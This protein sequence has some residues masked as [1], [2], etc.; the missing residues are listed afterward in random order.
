MA[1]SNKTDI[2]KFFNDDETV[3][4]SYSTKKSYYCRY[5]IYTDVELKNDIEFSTRAIPSE[6]TYKFMVVN[7]SLRNVYFINEDY[8]IMYSI[9]HEGS[10]NKPILTTPITTIPGLKY[11]VVDKLIEQYLSDQ[12][13]SSGTTSVVIKASN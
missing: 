13:L 4:F 7:K 1:R 10:G 11:E 6:F 2:L 3:H 9:I 12:K 5:T 8:N